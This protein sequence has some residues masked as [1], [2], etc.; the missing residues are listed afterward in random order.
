MKKIWECKIG[1]VDAAKLPKGADLPMREAVAVA[2]F[3]LTG[4]RCNFIFSGW[5]A[6]LTEPERAVIENRE[7]SFAHEAQWHAARVGVRP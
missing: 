6:E 5:G 3:E 4:E 2:F 7:P 1:E